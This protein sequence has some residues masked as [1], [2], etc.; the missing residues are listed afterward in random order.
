MLFTHFYLTQGNKW[1]P[2]LFLEQAD[3]FL[4]LMDHRQI[5]FV[6]LSVFC[7]LSNRP[8]SSCS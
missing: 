8:L 3:N 7:P 2:D 4:A 1:E 5:T 6:T